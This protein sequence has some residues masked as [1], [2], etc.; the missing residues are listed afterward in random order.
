[1]SANTKPTFD[2][3][4]REEHAADLEQLQQENIIWPWLAD[5]S[6]SDFSE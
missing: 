6:M 2:D 4:L 1:M 3:V 5:D